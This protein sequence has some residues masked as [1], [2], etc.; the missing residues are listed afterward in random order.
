MSVLGRACTTN[1]NRNFRCGRNDF[2]S[3][4]QIDNNGIHW[5]EFGTQLYCALISCR[6]FPSPRIV[7]KISDFF[8]LSFFA[9]SFKI[10]MSIGMLCECARVGLM[11]TSS[12]KYSNHFSVS[13]IRSLRIMTVHRIKRQRKIY[14][15]QSRSDRKWTG[16]LSSIDSPIKIKYF[17]SQKLLQTDFVL[18]QYLPTFYDKIWKNACARRRSKTIEFGSKNRANGENIFSM[19]KMHANRRSWHSIGIIC[20]ETEK[21]HHFHM[22]HIHTRVCLTANWKDVGQTKQFTGLSVRSIHFPFRPLAERKIFSF[23]LLMI[24]MKKGKRKKSL[25][26]D[27][28]EEIKMSWTERNRIVIANCHSKINRLVF[29][30]QEMWSKLKCYFS[31]FVK[32]RARTHKDDSKHLLQQSCFNYN[33]VNIII[34]IVVIGCRATTFRFYLPNG[35]WFDFISPKNKRK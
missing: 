12:R 32:S 22:Q 30:L 27:L 28:F 24:W 13:C 18:V 16:E 33:L 14:C 1:V 2:L 23:H 21:Y 4:Y 29:C 10:P 35:V 6:F 20:G 17:F 8:G 19:N 15:S 11:F 34:F 25:E 26:F 31:N 7:T 5:S 9:N 3:L